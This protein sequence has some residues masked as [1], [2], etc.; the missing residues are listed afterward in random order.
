M[1]SSRKSQAVPMS[2]LM[3]CVLPTH[4]KMSSYF[5]VFKLLRIKKPDSQRLLYFLPAHEMTLKNSIE[6]QARFSSTIR[7]EGV[8]GKRIDSFHGRL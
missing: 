7:R 6:M 3:L 5:I 4:L 2:S 8:K 1:Q